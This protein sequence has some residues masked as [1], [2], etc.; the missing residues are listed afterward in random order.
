[1]WEIA[2]TVGGFLLA[3][4]SFLIGRYSSIKSAGREDGEMKADIKHIKTGIESIQKDM[5][6]MN[7]DILGLRDRVT[8]LETLYKVEHERG[9]HV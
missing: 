7:N 4:I 6:D 8:T 1:M 3:V 2:I 5:A 9:S